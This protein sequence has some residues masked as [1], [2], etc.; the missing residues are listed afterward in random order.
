MVTRIKIKMGK[1]EK[2]MKEE[3]WILGFT[4]NWSVKYWSFR[5]DGFE[6]PLRDIHDV[7]TLDDEDGKHFKCWQKDSPTKK[8]EE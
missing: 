5:K 2:M 6:I 3:G 1:L 7:D 4:E 8:G